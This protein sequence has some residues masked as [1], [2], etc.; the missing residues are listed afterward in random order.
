MFKP[1][2]I[3]RKFEAGNGREII[4]RYPKMGDVGALLKFINKLVA[5]PNIGIAKTKKATKKE[6]ANWLK[7]NINAMKKGKLKMIVAEAGGKIIGETEIRIGQDVQKHVADFG[8]AIAKEYRSI[9]IG[10]EMMRTIF[11]EAKKI[12]MEI[13]TL[14]VFS[15]N[16]HAIKTYENMGFKP[17]GVLPKGIY[18]Y[19]KYADEIYM[20]KNI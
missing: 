5:E 7:S 2:K 17:F 11:E 6:E 19:K 18:K 14:K 9:G 12:G 3:I 16:N 4:L 13:I 20:F 1:G 8:I 15:F 10:T